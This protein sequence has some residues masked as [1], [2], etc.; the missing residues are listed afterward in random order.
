MFRQRPA[1]SDLATRTIAATNAS[2]AAEAAQPP[3]GAVTNRSN[4]T[5][6]SAQVV[7]SGDAMSACDGHTKTASVETVDRTHN[8]TS[9]IA[10]ERRM[11]YGGSADARL[12]A[13]CHKSST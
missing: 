3:D 13:P 6:A 11:R 9:W 12:A 2:A 5:L 8:A 1:K 4:R 7:S 10:A